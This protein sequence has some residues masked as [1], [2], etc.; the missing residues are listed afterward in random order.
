ML[1]L[2]KVQG[3][4]RR[5]LAVIDEVLSLIVKP[6]KS[7][8]YYPNAKIAVFV[9]YY[10]ASWVFEKHLQAFK[11]L[12]IKKFNY[13]VMANCVSS[14]ELIWFKS[15]IKKFAFPT[16]F[17]PWPKLRPLSHGQSIQRMIRSTNEEIIVLCDVDAF[18]IAHGWDEYIREKLE[19]K[20]V[21]AAIVDMPH[22]EL[23]PFLHPCIIAFKRKFIESNCLDVLAGEGNDPAYKITTFLQRTGRFKLEH[24][25]PLFPTK[26][27]IT[28]N[29][30]GTNTC[31]GRDDLIHGFG[32]TYGDMFCHFWFTRQIGDAGSITEPG[33]QVAKADIDAA[34][35]RVFRQL[36]EACAGA[37]GD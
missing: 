2:K 3:L 14:Q 8:A 16:V 35:V 6:K 11:S 19:K 32:T 20:D 4:F 24:V 23:T 17:F 22:R 29:S 34:I 5:T 10:K 15:I 36:D 37:S 25:E 30:K 13:Y 26:R 18:P 7:V 28:L 33:V 21:V 31:F 1:I 9:P 12:N 27:E